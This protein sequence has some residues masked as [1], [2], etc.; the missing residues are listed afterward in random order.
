MRPRR[1]ARRA[2]NAK[3]T[4][5]VHLNDPPVAVP[6]AEWDYTDATLTAIKLNAGSS[7]ATPT[8]G[9]KA[10]DIYEFAYIAKDP[11]PLGMGFAAMRDFNSFLRYCDEGR[12]RHA[13]S[14]RG[15]ITRIYT[16]ISS[17]PGRLLND[18]VHL[19]FNQD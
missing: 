18:F 7:H 17:Q 11:V 3:L 5:R 19:G 12:C 14:A 1:R 15:D 8:G 10:N 16:E 6:D 2:P 4:H 9:F 13:E